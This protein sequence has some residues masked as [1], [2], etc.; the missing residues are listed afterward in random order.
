MGDDLAMGKRLAEARSTG[1]AA[2][3]PFRFDHQGRAITRC[4]DV[5]TETLTVSEAEDLPT[6]GHEV[7]SH[8][9]D[10]VERGLLVAPLTAVTDRRHST[11]PAR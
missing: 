6:T 1:C 7:L 4:V 8:S 2:A 3:G 10:L 9:V 11:R 5:V